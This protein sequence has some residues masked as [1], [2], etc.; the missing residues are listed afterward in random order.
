MKKQIQMISFGAL[1]LATVLLLS[2]L[3]RT[4]EALVLPSIPVNVT[5]LEH[6]VLILDAGHGGEDGGAT[7]V[8]GALEKDL[9]L[10][11]T[12]SLAAMLRLCGYTVIETRTEDRLL[13]TEGT[14]KGHKKQSDLENRVAFT[15]KYPD[16]VFISIHMN[17]YPTPNCEGAQVWYSQNAPASKEWATA[18]QSSVSALLQPTNHRKIKAATSNIYVLRHAAAPAILVECGFLSTP[19]D[20][21]RLCDP[22]YQKQFALALC[23]AIF[24]KTATKS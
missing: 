7:G 15:A 16:S 24:E 11:L 13:Y 1:F 18:I 10:S 17:T 19:A 8:N 6:P 9:N 3:M 23:A 5:A 2:S 20:C 14:K 12:R 4:A 22:T 21:A